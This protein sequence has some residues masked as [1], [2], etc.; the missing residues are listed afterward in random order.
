MV[1]NLRVGTRSLGAERERRG[2]E[3]V[4]V[5]PNLLCQT[6]LAAPHTLRLAEGSGGGGHRTRLG[7]RKLMWSHHKED[8][9]MREGCGDSQVHQGSPCDLP[10]LPDW[11]TT[12]VAI[13]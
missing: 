13:A 5:H 4:S 2:W 12:N 1:L 8:R 6:A 11:T 3:P 9:L 10:G 7:T